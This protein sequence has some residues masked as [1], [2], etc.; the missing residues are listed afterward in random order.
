MSSAVQFKTRKETNFIVI[1]CAAT[2]PSMDVGVREIRQWHKQRGF[3]DIGYHYVI[4]RNGVIEEGRKQGQVGAHVAGYNSES[5]GVCLVGGVPENNVNGFE[6][7][8]TDAQMV[9]LKALVG[10]LQADYKTAKVVGHHH[11][12]SGKACPSFAVD[13][14]MNTGA[15]KTASKG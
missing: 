12:D 5:V 9:S 1:H 10:K 11:L 8:F 13:L 2:R 15:V 4:R 3:F 7:N 6:A 14:W